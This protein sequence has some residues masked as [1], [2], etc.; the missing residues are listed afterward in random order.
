MACLKGDYK[1]ASCFVF[2]LLYWQKLKLVYKQTY[3]GSNKDKKDHVKNKYY[4]KLT[5]ESTK[6]HKHIC[7]YIIKINKIN[8]YYLQLTKAEV[9][10][11]I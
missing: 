4:R 2:M 9:F 1:F 6:N 10:M 7:E 5:K 11:K 3:L 8:K